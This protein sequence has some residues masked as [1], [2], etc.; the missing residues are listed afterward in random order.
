MT[1]FAN[2]PES[3][4]FFSANFLISCQIYLFF[5]KKSLH[6]PGNNFP[7]KQLKPTGNFIPPPTSEIPKSRFLVVVTA[8]LHPHS[9]KIVR[10]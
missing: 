7:Q 5:N 1:F 8:F 4:E 2:K 3:F 9:G 6:P 10:L